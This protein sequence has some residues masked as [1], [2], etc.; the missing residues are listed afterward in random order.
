MGTPSDMPPEQA[1]GKL[2]EVGPATDV[3]EVGAIL[4]ECLTGWPPFKAATGV[5]TLQAGDRA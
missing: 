1:G 4:Y 5:E 3:Y 2:K